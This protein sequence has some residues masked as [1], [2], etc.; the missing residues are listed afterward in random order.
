MML[1]LA[2]NDFVGIMLTTQSFEFWHVSM[3]CTLTFLNK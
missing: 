2:D 1:M 3:S